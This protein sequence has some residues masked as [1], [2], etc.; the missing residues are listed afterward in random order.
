[1]K[2]FISTL[3]FSTLLVC[4][5]TPGKA[6]ANK[7]MVPEIELDVTLDFDSLSLDGKA[8]VTV[9]EL[10]RLD[11][12]LA[13][14][15]VA[16]VTL[17]GHD[18]SGALGADGMLH[19]GPI[20]SSRL[21][22]IHFKR[23]FSEEP[24]MSGF[25]SAH[26]AALLDKWYPA[27]QGLAVYN[28][29]VRVPE[30]LTV[31]SEA[32]N[33]ETAQEGRFSRFQFDFPYPRREVTLVAGRYDRASVE[34]RGITV[35]TFFFPEDR[36]LAGRYLSKMREYIDLYAD[37]LPKY[38][39]KRF[40]VVENVLPTGYGMATYTLLGSKV[41]RLPFIADTSLGHEFVHSWFGNSVYV[42]LQGGNWCEGLTT[43]LSDNLYRRLKGEGVDVRHQTL[44]EYQSWIHEDNALPVSEFLT[45]TD[46]RMRAVGYGKVSMI[47]HMLENELGSRAFNRG[48]RRLVSQYSFREASWEDIKKVFE[49]ESGHNLD[50]FFTQW[51]KRRDVPDFEFSKVSIEDVTGRKKK[52]SFTV[53]QRTAQPYTL[54]LPLRVALPGRD[55]DKK[56]EIDKKVNKISFNVPAKPYGVVADPDF[57]LMRKL[58]PD[59]F[60]PVLSRVFGASKKFYSVS[61]KERELYTPLIDL[62]VSRG[63]QEKKAGGHG[64]D[65]FKDGAFV[66]L[67]SPSE[68]MKMLA[69]DRKP[70]EQG[71]SVVV[72]SSPFGKTGVVCSVL[73]SSSEE[74]RAIV[75]K[76]PHYGRYSVLKFSKGKILEKHIE[77]AVSGIRLEIKRGITAVAARDIFP[78]K[79]IVRYISGDRVIYV[80]EQHDKVGHHKAQL[81]I[82]KLLHRRGV[83]LGVGMEMFQRPYQKALDRYIA[84]EIDERTFL[85][86]SEYFKRW[87][88]DY[89]LYRPIISYC[90][91]N[92]IP[93]VALNLRKEISKKIA[94]VGLDA[95]T[96]EE[97][98]ALPSHMDMSNRQY[99]EHLHSIFNQ[100]TA[101][102]LGNFDYFFQAQISWDETMAESVSSWL[103][104]HPDSSMVVIAGAGHIDY[105]FGIPSRVARR[106]PGIEYSIIINDPGE[107]MVPEAGDFFLFPPDEEQ[108]GS[109]KL[110]VSLTDD[111]NTLKVKGVMPGSPAARGGVKAG[112]VIVQF[113]GHPIRDINDLKTELFFKKLG[114]TA[115]L[116]V[117]RDGREIEIET[118]KFTSTSFSFGSPHGAAMGG[119]G[120]MHAMKPGHKRPPGTKAGT[121]KEKTTETK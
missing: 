12:S 116:R 54:T 68:G 104:A 102:M 30:G 107:D 120:G 115:R 2:L 31:I 26:N 36:E 24:A 32:D 18:L 79:K 72:S 71:V 86:E 7:V 42:D 117:L 111:N 48:L 19:I 100:H 10:R 44:V 27:F 51:L 53:T 81:E 82:I 22:E 25:M 13:G 46:R 75:S 67:G 20:N 87:G 64:H 93:V 38:P 74:L 56:I 105:A 76:L 35:E 17:N 113:D 66:I 80:S 58:H 85:R 90:R 57:D 55:I 98:S 91:E 95:L 28:L 21:L 37:I 47:F 23:Q 41:A 103:T 88:F 60:P 29:T 121:V 89:H 8:A 77:P 63:F 96:D 4:V 9:P 49:H 39:F 3:L 84:G 6:E 118:G 119:A 40:A 52:L 97:R 65:E 5:M 114:E 11:F 108:E 69:G 109:P 45:G 34:H 14:L 16:S 70:P 78:V 83:K 50:V 110:G 62:L 94:R 101:S 92:N 43:Y 106:M 33:I 112:D 1:M 99:R 73:A 15:E 61:D 59:E